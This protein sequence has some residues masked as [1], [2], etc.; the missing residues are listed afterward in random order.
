MEGQGV[1]KESIIGGSCEE[2]CNAHLPFEV[3]LKLLEMSRIRRRRA[4]WWIVISMLFW[5]WAKF[6][7]P[8]EYY[9]WCFLCFAL[10]TGSEIPQITHFPIFAPKGGKKR[11]AF[12]KLCPLFLVED[13]RKLKTKALNVSLLIKCMEMS[14]FSR[15]T[16]A[17][18][19]LI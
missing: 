19:M 13:S 12:V 11:R 2:S 4:E 9:S 7:L 6:N 16:R 18:N 8:G 14:F 15:S 17:T 10:R 5:L 1:S 3:F